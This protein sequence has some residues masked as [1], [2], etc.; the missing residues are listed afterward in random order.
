MTSPARFVQFRPLPDA[1]RGIL[2][3]TTD[4]TPTR[5]LPVTER[6]TSPERANHTLAKM[7]KIEML[8]LK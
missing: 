8:R 7:K 5:T 2:A 6:L 1:H 3:L 4:P